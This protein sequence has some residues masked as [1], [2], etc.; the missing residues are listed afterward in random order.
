MDLKSM[1]GFGRCESITDRYRINVELKSVNSRFLDLSVKMPKKFNALEAGIRGMVKDYIA[2]GKVDLYL[3]YDDYAEQSR[4]LRY[5]K[6]IA[7]EYMEH[8][9]QMAEDFALT[10]DIKVSMLA[11]FP[12][13]L[14]LDEKSEDDEELWAILEP[15]LRKALERFVATRVTEGENL[16]ADLIGKLD[17]MAEVVARIELRA[18]EII[19]AYRAKLTAKVEELLGNS[20]ID[21]ARIVSE[22][23]IFADKICTDEEI[24]RLKSHM[25]TMRG[26]LL[27]GGSVGRELDFIAQEMNRE[28]N[29]TLSKAND[30]IVSS[31]AIA[32]KT[33]IEKIREQIQNLE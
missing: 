27:Q 12:E 13:V 2:R 3:S 15:A 4:S 29:T 8:L 7:S 24:V 28:A 23:T 33:L 9:R 30:I 6:A 31:D 11:R 16:R 18:P 25:D 21:E 20:S 19:E 14:V 22:V 10:D 1:T 5:N 26:R 17:E 32:L